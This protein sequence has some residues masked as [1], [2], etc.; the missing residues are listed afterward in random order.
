MTF[1]SSSL[2]STCIKP[3]STPTPTVSDGRLT[4]TY[5]IKFTNVNQ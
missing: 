1:P 2:H 4:I 5:F 3:Q